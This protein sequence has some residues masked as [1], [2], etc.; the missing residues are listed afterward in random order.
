MMINYPVLNKKLT[1][2]WCF[3]VL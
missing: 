2:T 1:F 3:T